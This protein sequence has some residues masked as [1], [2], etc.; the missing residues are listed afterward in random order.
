[1]HKLGIKY[2]FN[3][4]QNNSVS[5][6]L[7]SQRPW[8]QGLEINKL[9]KKELYVGQGKCFH[10]FLCTLHVSE[11]VMK[12]PLFIVS[13]VIKIAK[14]YKKTVGHIALLMSNIM[15]VVTRR[16]SRHEMH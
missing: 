8:W 15:L 2:I 11:K 13:F 3:T 16:K 5:A 1:M 9:Q 14:L 6:L 7:S 10:I 12:R 4:I